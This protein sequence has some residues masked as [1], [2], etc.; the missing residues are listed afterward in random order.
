MAASRKKGGAKPKPPPIEGEILTDELSSA[1]DPQ[2]AGGG[3]DI[4]RRF[5]W[6]L[7]AAGVVFIAGLIAAPYIQDGIDSLL[8][9]KEPAPVAAPAAAESNEDVAATNIEEAP[10]TEVATPPEAVPQDET[11][12][13]IP[14]ETAED[15]LE[16][17]V[18]IASPDTDLAALDARVAA[19]E[20]APAKGGGLAERLDALEARLIALEGAEI[21]NV[22]ASADA[23]AENRIAALEARLA[24]VESREHIVSA[25][26]AN[27]V[28]A[29]GLLLALAR[30]SQRLDGGQAFSGEMLE[31]RAL[32]DALPAIDRSGNETHVALLEQHAAG[33]INNPA[34][35]RRSFAAQMPQALEAAALPQDA[36]WWDKV[37]AGLKSVV[38]VRRTGQ[39][40]GEGA[41]AILARIEFHLAEGDIAAALA[42]AQG[43]EPRVLETLALWQAD[44]ANYLAARQALEA[45][46]ETYSRRDG[47]IASPGEGG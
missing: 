26:A 2:G 32:F 13:G 5:V 46:I 18:A 14:T 39:V 29:D 1:G 47:A 36:G 24:E 20:A 30:M 7:T 12:A 11:P 45:L 22:A 10:A 33:G 31:F 35:L 19:L 38:V 34:M 6:Y 37:L 17:V 21:S 16:E 23:G 3:V 42:Q 4:F 40:E 44:A 8:G 41:E 27:A 9:G 43:L 15:I 25:G 28:S